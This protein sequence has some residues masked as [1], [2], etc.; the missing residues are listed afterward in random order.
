[1]QEEKARR[2]RQKLETLTETLGSGDTGALGIKQQAAIQ[3]FGQLQMQQCSIQGD[4]FKAELKLSRLADQLGIK[5]DADPT[6]PA[7]ANA[8][9]DIKPVVHSSSA[10]PPRLPAPQVDLMVENDASVI[11]QSELV[12]L[13]RQRFEKFLA[14]ASDSNE[15]VSKRRQHVEQ[16]EKKLASMKQSIRKN[17]EV[18]GTHDTALAEHNRRRDLLNQYN[19]AQNDLQV[20][21]VQEQLLKKE[22]DE[23]TAAADKIG[24]NSVNV[25]LTRK[26]LERLESINGRISTEIETLTVELSS[27]SRVQKLSEAREPQSRSQQERIK[28]MAGFGVLGF[29]LPGVGLLWMDMRRKLINNATELQQVSTVRVLGSVP[30][31]RRHRKNNQ[32]NTR[33]TLALR[34]AVDRI[35]TVLLRES[36][37]SDYRVVQITSAIAGEGKTTFACQLATSLARAHRRTVIADFDLRRPSVH[38]VFGANNGPGICEVLRGEA[39]LESVQQPTEQKDLWYIPAGKCD[40]EALEALTRKT[41]DEVIARLREQFELVVVDSSPVLPVVDA[42]LVAQR[43]DATIITALRDIT[44]APQ[45]LEAEDRL[46]QIGG[47]V[48]GSVVTTKGDEWYGDYRNH[49]IAN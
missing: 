47:N 3:R 23:A 46:R 24:T 48:V 28:K 31:V 15:F 41:A 11:K 5:R 1:M 20:L 43:C 44:R 26:D 36:E 42:L 49:Y 16:E 13:E 34:E 33:D 22:I 39:T 25:E 4:R 37:R 38:D 9:A 27:A 30:L 8:A 19:E 17:I 10:E 40:R 14:I 12:E 7:A 32:R 2:L 29:L 18:Y 21:Q 45:L 35:R 6:K